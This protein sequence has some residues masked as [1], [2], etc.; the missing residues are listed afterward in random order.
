MLMFKPNKLKYSKYFITSVV[1]R[2]P[3]LKE[4]TIENVL[5]HFEEKIIQE[6][7]RIGYTGYDFEEKKYLKV[8]T[9]ESNNIQIIFNAFYDRNFLKKRNK[10]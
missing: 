4:E 8:I 1:I 7:G 5:I 10:L 2:R 6:N 9:E 3:Y